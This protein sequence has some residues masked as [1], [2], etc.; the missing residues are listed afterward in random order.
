[1]KNKKNP[2]NFRFG[3]LKSLLSKNRN[4]F[5]KHAGGLFK[6]GTGGIPNYDTL[7]GYVYQSIFSK[8]ND[9]KDYVMVGIHSSGIELMVYT[10]ADV[11]K[12]SKNKVKFNSNQMIIARFS[13]SRSD[14]NSDG[15]MYKDDYDKVRLGPYTRKLMIQYVPNKNLCFFDNTLVAGISTN[16]ICNYLSNFTKK[17][18]PNAN[19]YYW[20]P[21]YKI[22]E[23]RIFLTHTFL[24]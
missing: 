1:V 22:R 11:E 8:T 3:S 7:A 15:F 18:K 23:I 2:K 13:K 4:R 20:D 14:Q 10:V 19:G 21:L 12:R 24:N 5:V 17:L 9:A 16:Y 6:G